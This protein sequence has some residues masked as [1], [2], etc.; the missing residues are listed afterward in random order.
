MKP[1]KFELIECP[2]CGYEYLPA[3]LFV[4]HSFLGKPQ[5]IDRTSEGKIISYDNTSVDTNESYVCDK[6]NHAFKI[7]AKLVFVTEED[8]L[9][10]FDEE[11]TSKLRK[12]VLFLEEC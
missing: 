6:C 4:S 10:N 3:E 9:E 5:N 1:R 7:A 8:K 12:N 2:V 11:Y